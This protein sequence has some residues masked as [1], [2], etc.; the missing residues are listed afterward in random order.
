MKSKH[1]FLKSKT[2]NAHRSSAVKATIFSSNCFTHAPTLSPHPFYINFDPHTTGYNLI[3]H[4]HTPNLTATTIPAATPSKP[5]H[6]LITSC[7]S[8]LEMDVRPQ[9]KMTPRKQIVL[10]N[11]R[12]IVVPSAG[13]QAAHYTDRSDREGLTFAKYNIRGQNKPR[14]FVS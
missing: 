13:C 14:P 5:G 8:R 9:A 12:T 6:I 3:S 4:T 2:S 11:I 10:Y 1:F 7:T